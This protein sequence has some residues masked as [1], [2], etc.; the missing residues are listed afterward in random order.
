MESNRA[1]AVKAT[2]S[3]SDSGSIVPWDHVSIGPA[4]L[5]VEDPVF[6]RGIPSKDG[7]H[8]TY[9][10]W[11]H[12]IDAVAETSFHATAVRLETPLAV[13]HQSQ[14]R[15][16]L[17]PRIH[18]L[19]FHWLRI[20]RD[21]QQFDYLNRDRMRLIQRETQ[22]DHMVIDG[23][24][25]L[26]VVLDDVRPGD[27]IEAAYSFV[28]A[29]P[30]RPGGCEALFSIPPGVVCGWFRFRLNFKSDHPG[31]GWM[32]AADAP[33]C[34][35]EHLLNE[36]KRWTWTGSQLLLREPEPCQPSGFFDY[37]WIQIS[38][39]SDWQ[40]LTSR[41]GEIWSLSQDGTDLTHLPA[42]SR[43]TEV[44]E[45]SVDRLVEHI[46]D[47]FRYL[48]VDLDSGGW[49]PMAPGIVAR[50]RYGDCKDLVWLA[51]N[52]LRAWGVSAH[53]IL[54]GSGLRSRVQTLRPMAILFNHAMLEVDFDGKTRWFDL[55]LRNQGGGFTD[56]AVPWFFHGL[57]VRSTATALAPQPGQ[58]SRTVYA[59]R[60][61]FLLGTRK[62]ESSLL[63]QRTWVEGWS[64]DNLRR[65][66]L[67]QG[68]EEFGKER[69][70]Q[71]QQHFSKATRV[72][73]LQ[74]RDDRERNI[75]E[76]AESFDIPDACYPDES[77]QRSLFDVPPNILIRNI[78]VPEKKARRAPWT[79]PAQMEIRHEIA[80]QNRKCGSGPRQRRS[81]ICPEFTAS[82]DEPREDGTWRKIVRFEIKVDEVAVDRVESYRSI[83]DSFLQ[84]TT[85]RLY[86]P[87]KESRP[88]SMEAFGVLPSSEAGV[89][90]YVGPAN[91]ADFEDV[92]A[93]PPVLPSDPATIYRPR[94]SSDNTWWIATPLMIVGL[95][96][97][98]RSCST[99]SSFTVPQV[100]S[101]PVQSSAPLPSR[102]P[103]FGDAGAPALLPPDPPI[104]GPIY[105]DRNN[106]DQIPEV[107][108]HVDATYPFE[109]R[110]HDTEGEAL[111]AFVVTDQGLPA[112]IRVV[113][114]THPAFGKAASI[115]ISQWHFRPAMKDGVAVAMEIRVPVSFRI[116]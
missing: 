8:V 11:D 93:L 12:Q 16:N 6:D 20:V 29:N 44:N 46:Q 105:Y 112:R 92:T 37:I 17:D 9:L 51:T 85:W 95:L 66:R 24:W 4:A 84:A 72:G 70:K 60:D 14:W 106:V 39:L 68:P 75:I 38:D 47:H 50:R 53:P 35:E 1:T 88:R 91:L 21:G 107:T 48:S 5:W 26:L 114:Q 113:T 111:I 97:A 79:V 74:W 63:E 81:W 103:N 115:A 77:G 56:R 23:Q 10:A 110:A 86:L 28:G 94:T 19:V 109:L 43:P 98:T 73:F 83:L 78:A 90:A 30:I 71:V 64:A 82:L 96:T 57:P 33:P 41:L 58:R 22:L 27:I 116:E 100:Y 55:T 65:D 87:T 52:V 15:L 61:T 67:A 36:R 31:M 62:G 45:E 101:P 89:A 13:Q 104:T 54:V 40:P 59:I 108:Q 76:M 69:L 49:I 2:G 7:A 80:I 25:T 3:Q 102:L 18:H 42:F 32:A 99:S 34:L